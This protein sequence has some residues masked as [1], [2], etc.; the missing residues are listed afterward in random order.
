MDAFGRFAV[1]TEGTANSFRWHFEVGQFSPLYIRNR[2]WGNGALFGYRAYSM[3]LELVAFL[4]GLGWKQKLLGGFASLFFLVLLMY[5][6]FG[7]YIHFSRDYGGVRYIM[8]YRYSFMFMVCLKSG[9][10]R[11]FI[12]KYHLEAILWSLLSWAHLGGPNFVL[13]FILRE[14]WGKGNL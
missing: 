9:Y 6:S 14:G 3:H 10:I 11:V 5:Y 2:L 13:D 4:S 1:V 12:P 7:W 8:E